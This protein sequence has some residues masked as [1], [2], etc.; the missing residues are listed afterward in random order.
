MKPIKIISIFLLM[1]INWIGLGQATTPILIS[2]DMITTGAQQLKVYLPLIKGKKTG[3]VANQASVVNSVHLVD[4]LLDRQIE[5]MAILS[6]EHGFRGSAE[7]GEVV[8]DGK[9]IKTGIPVISLYGNHRKPTETDLQ[10]I[11]VIIFDLQDVGTRFFTYISTLTYVMEACAMHDIQLIVLDRP[12]PNGF[13]VDGPVL[14]TAYKSFVGL[15]PVPVVYGMTIGE[16]AM[17]VKGE[18]WIESESKCNLKVISLLGYTRNMIAELPVKPSP[19]LPNWKAV[20]LYPSLCFFEGTIM[21]EG[22]GTDYPFQIYGHPNFVPGSS[23]FI[24]ESRPGA[25]LHPKF[26]G[27]HC[28]G[29]SLWGYAENYKHN[30]NQINL[31]W[32]IGSYEILSGKFEY[33][34]D[35]F[36]VLAGTNQ[37]RKQIEAGKTEE[38]IRESWQAE[39][40][41]FKK[42]REK[43]LIYD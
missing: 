33:F 26:E 9:D 15:H 14:D 20:Y 2:Y 28:Y 3:V 24:P 29:Q 7:A 4:L 27:E 31:S 17:M 23:V 30:Q 42:I 25:S 41:K 32:L 11:E 19:N 37:L 21:S 22:R 12:N 10:N 34:N 8:K 39:L 36:D 43:Y 18:Q 35:Y 40:E 16:Y 6:P 5:V 13:Y 1:A 38:E